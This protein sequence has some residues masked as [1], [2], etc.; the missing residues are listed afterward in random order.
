MWKNKI[1]VLLFIIALLLKAFNKTGQ[2]MIVAVETNV[3]GRIHDANAAQNNFH[4]QQILQNKFALG[5][6]GYAGVS[7]IIAGYKSNEIHQM[8]NLY[9]IKSLD[10]NKLGLNMSIGILN[11][12]KCYQ[13]IYSLFIT[14]Q[15][16]LDVYF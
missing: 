10:K 4:F 8:C 11:N 6:P 5:D 9:L 2:I 15:C 16:M 1:N 14:E 7:Y 3:K 12:V 13:S